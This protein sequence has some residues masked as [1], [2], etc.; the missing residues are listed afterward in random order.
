M[1][2]LTPILDK[3]NESVGKSKNRVRRVIVMDESETS[4]PI[5][6]ENVDITPEMIDDAFR[7]NQVKSE[8]KN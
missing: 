4:K 5:V 2:G 7:F 6:L 1:F 8:K 3:D